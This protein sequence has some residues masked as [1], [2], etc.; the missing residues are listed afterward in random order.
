MSYE[1][2]V[3]A[4]NLP[5]SHQR[6]VPYDHVSLDS[7]LQSSSSG[8]HQQNYGGN[9]GLA[10]A[11]SSHSRE[12]LHVLDE[13]SGSSF[14]VSNEIQDYFVKN[15]G[16][17][18]CRTSSVGPTHIPSVDQ[19]LP[20]VHTDGQDSGVE[21]LGMTSPISPDGLDLGSCTTLPQKVCLLILIIMYGQTQLETVQPFDHFWL[22]WMVLSFE[23]VC[24]RNTNHPSKFL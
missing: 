15:I 3:S 8:Y 10:F 12:D 19:R 16:F 7:M 1:S 14:H 4:S 24:V 11:A 13:S 17:R 6:S 18:Q 9:E 22:F 23:Y 20:V 5:I 2:T 21:D